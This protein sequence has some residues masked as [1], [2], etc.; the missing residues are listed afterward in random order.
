MYFSIWL[1][2]TNMRQPGSV[3][4]FFCGEVFQAFQVF[5]IVGTSISHRLLAVANCRDNQTPT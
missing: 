5:S 2:L 4:A 1:L 3:V